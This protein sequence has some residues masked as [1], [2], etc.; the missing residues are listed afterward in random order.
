MAYKKKTWQEKLAGPPGFPKII[1]L[2]PG[3]PCARALQKAGAKPGDTVVLVPPEE[4]YEMMAQVPRGKLITL[5]EICRH[6]ASHHNAQYCCTLTTGIAIVTAANAA[7][8]AGETLPYW[9]TIKNN[10]E[11]NTK[12]PGGIAQHRQL[13]EKEG[14]HIRQSGKKAFVQDFMRHLFQPAA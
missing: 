9:R 13:L 12:Y 4:V 10:G 3:L 7:V 11:L 14:F 6:L 1:S 8:E 5:G 2:A